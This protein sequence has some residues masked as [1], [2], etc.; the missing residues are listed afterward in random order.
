[1]H[2][3]LTL[4]QCLALAHST[5]LARVDK[6]FFYSYMYKSRRLCC[7]LAV[8]AEIPKKACAFFSA[9]KCPH[10]Y[11]TAWGMHT[12]YPATPTGPHA[13]YD[14]TYIVRHLAPPITFSDED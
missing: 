11:S 4:E 2:H 6:T 9:S 8:G 14:N 10:T 3:P 5:Q 1:M 7:R 12:S 13:A